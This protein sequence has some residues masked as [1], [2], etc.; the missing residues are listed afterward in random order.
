MGTVAGS[1]LFFRW[2]DS[3]HRLRSAKKRRKKELIHDFIQANPSLSL[4]LRSVYLSV[5]LSVSVSVS[6]SLS[7]S[8][9]LRETFA[10]SA[11]CLCDLIELVESAVLLVVTAISRAVCRFVGAAMFGLG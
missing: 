5:C 1:W 8:L 11:R 10:V 9:V 2:A 4:S 7:L 3:L 6:L